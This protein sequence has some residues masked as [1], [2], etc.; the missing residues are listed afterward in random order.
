MLQYVIAGLVIG[1]IY[2]IAA[3]GLTL[4]YA[5]A[6]ILN[7]SF[8]ALAYFVARFFY[9]LHSQHHWGLLPSA[10]VALFVVGPLLGV[11]LYLVL[12]RMLQLASTLIKIVAT[13]GVSVC[14]PPLATLLFG[15]VTIVEAPGLAPEPVIVYHVLGVPVTMDQIIDYGCVLAVV[16]LGF[17][18]LRYTDVGLRVRAMVDSP[19]MTSLSGSS[20]AVVSIGVWAVSVFLAGLAGVLS[21]PIIG[22]DPTDY[23]LLMASA[24]AAVVAARLRNVPVAVAVGLVIGIAGSLVQHYLPPSSSFTAAVIP[25]IPFVVTVIFLIYH[26]VRYG[27]ADESE[28]VGGA[29]D[30]AIQPHGGSRLAARPSAGAPGP[31]P[32]LHWPPAVLG[33]AVL[34]AAAFV[35]SSFWVGL[36]AEGAAFAIIFLAFTLVVGEGGMIWA[37]EVTFAGVGAVAA[38]QFATGHGW[39]VLA[40]VVAGGLIAVPLGVIIGM[41]TIRLGGL[42][43]TLVTLMFGLLMDNLVFTRTIFTQNGIGVT[44]PTPGF[45]TTSRAL[46]FLG[47]GV[48]CAVSLLIVN[49]RR[50]T[51]GLALSAVRFS[52]AGSKTIG[53]SVLQMKVLVAGVAAFVA[54]IGGAILAM[55]SG[56][57]LP[58]NYATLGGIVW[59]AVLVTAGIRSNMAAL[60]AGMMFTVLPGITLEYLPA[61]WGQV[62]PI[63]FGVGAVLVAKNPDGWMAQQADQIRWLWRRLRGSG[64]VTAPAAARPAAELLTTEP[65]P[66]PR[67]LSEV[68]DR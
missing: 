11:F 48:F 3:A 32:P 41:L 17:V 6:G 22:L 46:L 8:G 15:N 18:V 50:S 52:E 19:A 59:L 45:A 37:C 28:G 30:R 1:G 35:L 64:D 10:V 66:P 68:Q 25:S 62:P 38:A 67:G 13:L 40:A 63:L 33:I 56:S 4:T 12:F 2:A 27:R 49:I 60:V 34:C 51:T 20:P 9:W 7:F 23:T 58:G 21:A 54:A 65:A 24:F 47:L 42:Y 5:S 31:G 16:I 44:M 29:L 43:V 53:L 57:A 39:P 61:S 14:V 36:L 26:L 55:N